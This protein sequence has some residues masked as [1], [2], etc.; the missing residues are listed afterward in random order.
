MADYRRSVGRH[1]SAHWKNRS[2][3]SDPT[4]HEYERI[5]R[6]FDVANEPSAPEKLLRYVRRHQDFTAAGTV[7]DCYNIVSAKTLLSIG[8][9][10]LAKLK[11]PI[12]LRPV[13]STDVFIPLGESE[14]KSCSGEYAYVDP[15]G[16][17]ICRM[18]VLQGDFTKVDATSHDIAFFLQ[19]NREIPPQDLLT[20]AWLLAELTERFCGG[21]AELVSFQEPTT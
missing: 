13:E 4:L 21:T 10:D 5:H 11:T 18:E 7:V 9:H 1:L 15:D 3:S 14:P 6:L 20:G 16:R 8:A 19:G 2:L 17:I 12:T